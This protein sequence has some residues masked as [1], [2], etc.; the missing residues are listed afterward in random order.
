MAP[1]AGDGEGGADPGPGGPPS[2]S[3][4][5]KCAAVGAAQVGFATERARSGSVPSR[6]LF[7]NPAFQK[8]LRQLMCCSAGERNGSTW[9]QARIKGGRKGGA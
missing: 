5:I 9:E 3:H 6:C 2:P 4:Y 8:H 1:E 7:W